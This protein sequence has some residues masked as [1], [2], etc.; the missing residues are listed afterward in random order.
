MVKKTDRHMWMWSG[1]L[2]NALLQ[3]RFLAAPRV[4]ELTANLLAVRPRGM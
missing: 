3:S 1:S 2:L 4:T